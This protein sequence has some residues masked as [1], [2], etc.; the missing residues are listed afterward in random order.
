MQ[1]YNM[2]LVNAFTDRAF[3]GNATGVIIHTGKLTTDEMQNTAKD[4]NQDVTVFI[5]RLDIGLYSTRFFTRKREIKLCGHATIATF[6]ALAQNEYIQHEDNDIVEVSQLTGLGRVPVK[7]EYKNSKVSNVYMNLDVSC[8]ERHITNEEITRAT[9]LT[10]KEIGLNGAY[11]EPQK[12]SMGSCD[13]VI[14][15]QSKEI[16][17]KIKIDYDYMQKISEKD[18]IISFQVFTI[19]ETKDGVAKVMQRTF[20]P[21]ICVEE[22]AGSGTSTGATLYYINR[23]VSEDI[24]KIKSVQGVEIGRKSILEAELIDENTVQVGGRA[25]IFMNGVLNI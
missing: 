4:L 24:K 17:E 5:R 10:E 22:E 25:Y 6:Y 3:T 1:Y 18:N 16:L 21:S 12:I 23:N 13:L 19:E 14:P 15:V 8:E 9:G 2:Y 7:V 11:M 20:S